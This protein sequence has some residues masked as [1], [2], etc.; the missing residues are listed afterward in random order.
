M[1][2]IVTIDF[3]IIMAPSIGLYNNLVPG[4]S[5]E[6]LKNDPYFELLKIDAIHYQKIFNYIMH[7]VQYLPKENIHFIEDHGQAVKYIQDKC[8]LIN[9]DHHHDVGYGD[10]IEKQESP[11]CANWVYH[12]D[13]CHLVNTYTWINN[14]NSEIIP[15]EKSPLSATMVVHSLQNFDL[16]SLPV[17]DELIICLSEPWTPPYIRPLYYTIVDICNKYYGTHF[18]IVSGP[19]LTTNQGGP[20][21]A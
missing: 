17:P 18:D 9:V 10:D 8:D 3:D 2:T 15:V 6:Q 14:D 5:W 21:H 13:K 7:C 19:Y 16:E 12:L 20:K 1:K 4:N 11:T